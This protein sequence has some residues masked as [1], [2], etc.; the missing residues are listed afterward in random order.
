MGEMS[1]KNKLRRL[2]GLIEGHENKVAEQVSKRTSMNK[3][4]VKDR[5]YKIQRKVDK[6]SNTDNRDQTRADDS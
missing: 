3:N 4:Q 5:I 1:V 6:D 2:I